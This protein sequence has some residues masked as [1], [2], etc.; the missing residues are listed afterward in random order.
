MAK[1]LVVDD[2]KFQLMFLSEVLST[3]G[4]EPVA[5]SSAIEALKTDLGDIAL[6]LSDVEMPHMDGRSLVEAI[7][8][9]KGSEIPF[10]FV[11]GTA[12]PRALV[13]DAIQYQAE[14]IS[15]PIVPEELVELVQRMIG[16]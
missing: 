7:R 5:V 14:F 10:V 12:D 11:T 3:A 4:F 16:G 6:V 8:T 9:V 13:A 2:D 15:K 1:I